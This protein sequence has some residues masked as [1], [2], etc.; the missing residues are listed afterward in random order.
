[1][2]ETLL[3]SSTDAEWMDAILF[4]RGGA[5]RFIRGGAGRFI[6]GGAGRFMVRV[7][8]CPCVRR[9]LRIKREENLILWGC[10]RCSTVNIVFSGRAVAPPPTRP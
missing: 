1:M 9:V 2:N 4:I 10:I 5:G 8:L 6:R 7:N 3:F